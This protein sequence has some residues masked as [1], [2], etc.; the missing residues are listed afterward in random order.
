MT[1]MARRPPRTLLELCVAKGGTLKG[2]RVAAFISCWAIASNAKGGPITL[3]DYAEWW[4][5][6]ERTAFR[7]QANFR[8]LFPHLETPQLIVDELLRHAAD[9]LAE[10]GMKS[11]MGQPAP[12]LAL[13]A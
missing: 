12:S 4:C 6:N 13:A 1:P 7:H 9:R 11:L 8:A 2:A 3:D 10:Q 5:E